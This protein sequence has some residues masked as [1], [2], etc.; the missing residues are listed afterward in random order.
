M[1][2]T[3]DDV[4]NDLEI[5]EEYAFLTPKEAV[6][7]I[8]S[9]I[10]FKPLKQSVLKIKL[11]GWPKLFGKSSNDVFIKCV[12]VIKKVCYLE[13]VDSLKLLEDIYKR[14]KNDDVRSHVL[15][16]V[17]N[18]SKYNLFALQQ[19]EYLPQNLI[20]KSINRFSAKKL[21]ENA[22]IIF[23]VARELL[24]PTYEG[25][26]YPDYKTITLHSGP[27]VVS[28]KLKGLR[29]ESIKLLEKLYYA[30]NELSKRT[31]VIQILQE[32]T[33]TPHSHVYS[34][35]ME[36]MVLDDTNSVIDF[37]I[38]ILPEAK[39][40]IIQQIEEQKAWFIRRFVKNPPQK[41]KEL[42]E[43]IDK[44]ER[45]SVYRV[46]VGWDGRLD[47]DFDFDKT[48]KDRTEKIHKFVSEIS[49]DNFEEW[50]SK[51]LSVIQNYYSSDPGIYSYFGVFLTELG[52][53]KPEIALRIIQLNEKELKPFLVSLLIGIWKGD[54]VKAKILI[55]QWID[56]KKNLTVC[57]YLL[58]IVDDIDLEIIKQIFLSAKATKDIGALNNLLRA[59]VEK[60]GQN[61]NLKY[62]FIE[63]I[64]ELTINNDTS[65]VNNLWFKQSPLFSDIND[66][67]IDTILDGMILCTR[68]DYQ[69]EEILKTIAEKF[70]KKIIDFFYRRVLI[71]SKKKELITDYY[72]AIP[73]NLNKLR[74]VLEGHAT[75]TVPLIFK[76]YDAGDKKQNGL[77]EWEAGEL[78]EKIFPQFNPVLEK[79]L[80]ETIKKNGDIGM[81]IAF[82]IIGR[83]TGE[84]FLWGIIKAL[85]KKHVNTKKYKEVKGHLFGYLS[86]TGVVSGEDGFVRSFKSKKQAIKIFEKD[87]DIKVR[88]FFEEYKN[89]LDKK[90]IAEQKR[91]NEEIELMKRGIQ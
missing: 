90:I 70:P 50:R 4:F 69:A 38:K 37:Y 26:S 77:F 16:A 3:N 8:G 51:I 14:C 28:D 30:T 42:S 15:K 12:D 10:R 57:A 59:I 62:Y 66:K 21:N 44:N 36:G 49:E 76:W 17:E 81:K 19:V 46:F 68:I 83:Y 25:R 27:L 45:Y 84:E 47:P 39:N 82:S 48:K 65:W 13:T 75:I 52:Q 54:S 31:K 7:I 20:L 87:A 88:N 58:S 72:D 78:L 32:A 86:Q 9:V 41:I 5:L 1:Y 80:I 85:I 73:F 35:D 55:N 6:R 89:Y 22:E 53:N 56:E 79:L 23:V 67:E 64:K 40:E 71:R 74:T 61:K 33:Q 63:T 91:T 18:L 24:S 2:R 34:D 43:I 29:K 60:Y 11:K